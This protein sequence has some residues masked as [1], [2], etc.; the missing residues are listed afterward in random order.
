MEDNPKDIEEP[1]EEE[2]KDQT[3]P[4]GVQKKKKKNKNKGKKV[5]EV[6]VDFTDA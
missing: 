4:D 6:K 5:Q 2:V 3:Q 1:T